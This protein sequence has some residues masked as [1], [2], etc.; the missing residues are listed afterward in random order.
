VRHGT[1][2]VTCNRSTVVIAAA[3]SSPTM[4]VA[5]VLAIVIIIIPPPALSPAP[6][7]QQAPD[8]E[9]GDQRD[10]QGRCGAETV[11]D[12]EN[13]RAV[14]GA[15]TFLTARG[16]LPLR[17][18]M[19]GLAPHSAARRLPGG[20]FHLPYGAGWRTGVSRSATGGA[21]PPKA[22]DLLSDTDR[23]Q[24]HPCLRKTAGCRNAPEFHEAAGPVLSD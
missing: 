14:P 1:A 11:H 8:Q 7:A 9:G 5:T 17:L 2:A 3:I 20:C 19:G 6:C 16:A 15:S 21:S 10:N 23:S 4:M 12:V 13:R 22:P 18:I 24:C